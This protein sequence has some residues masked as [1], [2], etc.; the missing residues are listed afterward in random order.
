MCRE[1]EC[2]LFRAYHLF[3]IETHVYWHGED[4]TEPVDQAE[5]K[6]VL[7]F[8]QHYQAIVDGLFRMDLIWIQPMD[9]PVTKS[10]S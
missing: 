4:T 2:G 8:N 9:V 6:S 1:K 7:L 10:G 3:D 5:V